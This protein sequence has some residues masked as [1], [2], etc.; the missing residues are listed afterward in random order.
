MHASI[1]GLSDGEVQRWAW[2][3]DE[4]FSRF[5]RGISYPADIKRKNPVRAQNRMN[6]TFLFLEFLK[7]D[8]LLR[9][10]SER[11]TMETAS[12]LTVRPFYWRAV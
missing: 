5:A 12:E 4:L 6:T 1:V 11:P 7:T 2:F 10:L 9:V 8:F 3:W